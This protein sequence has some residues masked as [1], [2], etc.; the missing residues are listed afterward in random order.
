MIDVTKPLLPRLLAM[1][2]LAGTMPA[3]A[4][5]APPTDAPPPPA[6]ADQP[7]P[8]PPDYGLVTSWAARPGAA[9]ASAS[10]PANA[11]RLARRPDA[12]VFYIHPTTYRTPDHWNQDIANEEVNRWTDA[13][14]IARQA[15]VFNGCCRIFAPRYR[16]ASF[17]ATR[18]RFMT[19]DGGR[20]YAL[21]YSDVLRAFDHYMANDNHG[22]PFIIAGHSQGAEMARRLLIDRIDGQSA[23]RHMVAAYVIGLDL[24]EGD[25]GR[26]YRQL[27]PCHAPAQT[28]CVLAWN[29]VAAD[30][31]LSLFRQF[32]GVR[33]MARYGTEEGRQ[34][35][36]INPLSWRHDETA[37][38]ASANP[39]SVPG[40][41]GEGAM[42]SLR[43]G[44]AGARCDGGFLL[45]ERDPSLGLQ[46]LPG[47]VLHYHEFGL[48]YASIRANI[49]TRIRAWRRGDRR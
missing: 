15:G 41:P 30:A 49:A 47:G 42:Q 18:D 35:L 14:V 37:V 2:L 11:S 31:D 16:Q 20:A 44:L 33:Y 7:A 25:F 3:T 27:Q 5:N 40:M 9:G 1:L 4:Q 39:G 12:D 24:T 23:A 6:F 26:T 22:R 29:A 13:S 36:C 46:A 8:P 19:G 34:S 28:G 32:A 48:F 17:L 45:V 43:R 38:P 10:R 21:A